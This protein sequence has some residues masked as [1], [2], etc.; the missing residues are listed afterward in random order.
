MDILIFLVGAAFLAVLASLGLGIA[1][2]VTHGE[3]AHHTSG[4]WMTMR[5]VLQGVALALAL[6]AVV[7]A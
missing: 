7:A 6:L 5:V 1:S 4:E 3:V 2:M